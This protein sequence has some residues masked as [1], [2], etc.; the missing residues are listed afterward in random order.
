MAP[1]LPCQQSVGELHL[2]EPEHLMLKAGGRSAPKQRLRWGAAL[3][4]SASLCQHVPW[5][6][7]KEG[8]LAPA[9]HHAEHSQDTMVS[10]KES[11]SAT[12]ARKAL[13]RLPGKWQ[14]VGS[15]TL[16]YA[17]PKAG[18]SCGRLCCP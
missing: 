5:V 11:L 8:A 16:S 9:R 17:H 13:L 18:N 7:G 15:S 1:C 4:V 14:C 6:D 2:H 12:V 10:N 3:Q